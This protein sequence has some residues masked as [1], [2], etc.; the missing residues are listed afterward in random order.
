MGDIADGSNA[1]THTTVFFGIN[2]LCRLSFVNL[3]MFDQFGKKKSSG[4]FTD[5]FF[6]SGFLMT[7]GIPFCGCK[8]ERH[9]VIYYTVCTARQLSVLP[10]LPR[11]TSEKAWSTL[12]D[13]CNLSLDRMTMSWIRVTV[14]LCKSFHLCYILMVEVNNRGCP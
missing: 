11:S 12:A 6:K 3:E 2:F 14:E 8:A 7:I 5:F 13:A 10:C 1:L 9:T 4:S